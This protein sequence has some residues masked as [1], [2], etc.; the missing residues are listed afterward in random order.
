MLI[1][2]TSHEIIDFQE[3]PSEFVNLALDTVEKQQSETSKTQAMQ[4]LE[5]MCGQIDGVLSYTV[6]ML[7]QMIDFTLV[8]GELSAIP[9][10]FP[11]L[12]DYQESAF[13]VKTNPLI[14]METCLL[15]LSAIGYLVSRRTDLMYLEIL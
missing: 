2:T 9:E 8:G 7:L 10:K 13:L 4:F 3:N 6:V 12:V 11:R 15:I 5:H 1:K 14:R